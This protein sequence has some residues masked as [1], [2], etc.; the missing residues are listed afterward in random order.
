MSM[1]TCSIGVGLPG[2]LI[3]TNKLLPFN[4][5]FG[6]GL[7]FTDAVVGTP[8]LVAPTEMVGVL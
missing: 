3:V 1:N 4:L 2:V 5:V 6:N 8:K 7:M